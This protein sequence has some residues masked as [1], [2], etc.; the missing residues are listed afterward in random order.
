MIP[1]RLALVLGIGLAACAGPGRRAASPA[2][3]PPPACTVPPSDLH[4]S[5]LRR[6][7]ADG[8]SALD[9]PRAPFSL[10]A[11]RACRPAVLVLPLAP[12]DF[13]LGDAAVP[14]LATVLGVFASFRQLA[15]ERAPDFVLAQ[16]PGDVAA[17]RCAGATAYVFALEGSRVLEGHLDALPA[18]RAAGVRMVGVA[19]AFHDS[20]V[21]PAPG[22]APPPGP[23][24]TA[25]D[26]RLSPE[27]ERLVR[28]LF[29][30]GLLV[31]VAHLPPPAFWRVVALA[32]DAGRPLVASHAGAR[33][34]RDVPRNLDDDQLRAIARTG[35]LVGVA[36]HTPLL[37]ADATADLDDVL[38][39]L[40]WMARVMGPEHVA[41]GSDL[42]GRTWPPPD[43][44]RFADLT[45]IAEGLR[46]RGL[47]AEDVERVLRRNVVR[48]LDAPR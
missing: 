5:L 9:D 33:A 7:E 1:S 34:L 13:G 47:S 4:A 25:P 27:G 36:L 26:S 8:A 24:R 23:S 31:D 43:L 20:F 38:D 18:L 6:F 17:A 14:D 22:R 2:P 12:P 30:E 32:E 21:V 3:P 48:L 10:A 15:A 29:R 42:D 45:R 37:T 46:R 40:T 16:G 11:V 28:A 19:H 39:H 41:L 44:A 35:G